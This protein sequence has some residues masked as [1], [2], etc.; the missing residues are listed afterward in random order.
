MKRIFI[1]MALALSG[2][3]IIPCAQAH[4]ASDAYAQIHSESR[5]DGQTAWRV[6]ISLA[7]KD[8]DVVIPSLDANDNRQ[9]TWGEIRTTLP[10][11][12]QSVTDATSWRC[13]PKA[14]KPSWAFESLEQRSDGAYVRLGTELNCTAEQHRENSSLTLE[15]RFMRNQDPTHRLLVAGQIG[16]QSIAAVLAPASTHNTLSLAGE[17]LK[18]ASPTDSADATQRVKTQTTANNFTNGLNTL[19]RFF[20]EGLHHIATGYDH[21]AFL[22]TLLLPIRLRRRSAHADFTFERHSGLR[23][24]LLTVSA[25]TLGHSITLALATLGFIGSP[26]WVEPAIAITIAISALLNLRP[27]SWPHPVWLHP[28]SWALGFGL[29]HGLGFSNVMREAGVAN[30]VLPWALGGFNLGVEAGQLAGV[31][32][33]CVLH[34]MLAGWKHY[35]RLVVQGG[36]MALL[37][38]AV[39]WL[40]QRMGV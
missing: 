13:G 14:I 15:Y 40:W 22:L 6:Q 28:S 38:L 36:S 1:A 21:L 20:P 39:F 26:A 33:W 9:V 27:A 32:A 18:D 11:I 19:A 7:V 4:K 12:T 29:I 30:Q 34:S 17:D 37:L 5:S 2:L 16:A 3:L 23:T 31:A 8:L 24:L 25:F 35:E 10:L